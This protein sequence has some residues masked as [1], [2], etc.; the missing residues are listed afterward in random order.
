MVFQL[1]VQIILSVVI[2]QKKL[3]TKKEYVI[4]DFGGWYPTRY[5][6]EIV[7]ENKLIDYIALGNEEKSTEYLL[8][9]LIKN[10][11]FQCNLEIKHY[12][13]V[14]PFDIDNKK[15]YFNTNIRWG[16]SYD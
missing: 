10:K 3:R 6:R 1:M 15:D 12:S 7:Y 14:T 2:L 5:Y 4:I 13:I 8:E 11:F 9:H 16:P